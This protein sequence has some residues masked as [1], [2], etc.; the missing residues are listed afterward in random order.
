MYGVWI[1][2]ERVNNEVLNNYNNTDFAFVFS[3]KLEKNATNYGKHVYQ[4][5]LMT[6]DGYR[7]YYNE[8]ISDK[9]NTL[10]SRVLTKDSTK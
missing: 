7:K 2:G 8:K 6:N 5:N 3:S 4:V 9:G 1:N 10:V